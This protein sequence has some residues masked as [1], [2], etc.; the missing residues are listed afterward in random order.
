[1][2]PTVTFHGA[3]GTVTGSCFELAF[4]RRR[5]LVDC[6][7]FQGSRSLEALNRAP[8]GFVPAKLDAVLVTHA[9]LDHSGSCRASSRK[10][11]RVQ[12]GAR[13]RPGTCSARC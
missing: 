12:Y 5:I 11:I 8:F 6:G 10:D 1:V 7:L 2:T 3:V 13:R 9:H 4:G